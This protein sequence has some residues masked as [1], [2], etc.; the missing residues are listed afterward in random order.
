MIDKSNNKIFNI[1]LKNNEEFISYIDDTFQKVF[2]LFSEKKIKQSLNQL[3]F[4]NKFYHD[5]FDLKKEH[6]KGFMFSYTGFVNKT[7]GLI[8]N[9]GLLSIEDI[10][11]VRWSFKVPINEIKQKVELKEVICV[12][13]PITLLKISEN[14]STIEIWKNN[15]NRFKE[16]ELGLNEK[17]NQ[18]YIDLIL[19]NED[20]NISGL[21][22]LDLKNIIYPISKINQLSNNK[23]I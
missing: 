4:I 8:E 23:K 2:D 13:K 21:L 11:S 12:F 22:E 15:I 5:L 10:N 20:L 6:V 18:E 16:L 1:I 7:N 9:Y 19:I 14:K 3:D 17:I